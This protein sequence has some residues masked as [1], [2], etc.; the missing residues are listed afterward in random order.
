MKEDFQEEVA[1]GLCV[2]ELDWKGC[3]W[4]GK[5]FESREPKRA[6]SVA[7]GKGSGDCLYAPGIKEGVGGLAFVCFAM[8]QTHSGTRG[9]FGSAPAAFFLTYDGQGSDPAK[10]LSPKSLKGQAGLLFNHCWQ[11]PQLI[12]VL[13]GEDFRKGNQE[14]A[15]VSSGAWPQSV[16]GSLWTSLP[17]LTYWI[18]STWPVHSTVC[19]EHQVVI[20]NNKSQ[21]QECVQCFSAMFIGFYFQVSILLTHLRVLGAPSPSSPTA[22][23]H[24][25][26]IRLHQQLLIMWPWLSHSRPW[27]RSSL[28]P[29]KYSSSPFTSKLMSPYSPSLLWAQGQW[30]APQGENPHLRYY[31][32]RFSPRAQQLSSS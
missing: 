7:Q 20:N 13:R 31:S 8:T 3:L 16:T 26:L 27:P 29:S 17:H 30:S 32:P 10:I 24:P 28:T 4:L 1:P 12:L 21:A 14:T 22:R 23:H 5:N 9:T 11:A 18:N 2:L 19:W 6:K 25:P 15:L